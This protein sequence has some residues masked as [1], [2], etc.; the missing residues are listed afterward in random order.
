MGSADGRK[1]GVDAMLPYDAGDV[2][3][4]SQFHA[5]GASPFGASIMFKIF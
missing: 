1:K 4:G 2:A 3:Y 5:L